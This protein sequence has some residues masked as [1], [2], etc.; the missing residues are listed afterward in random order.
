MSLRA[1][2]DLFSYG[3][4]S[5]DHHRETCSRML[6]IQIDAD[7]CS[8]TK[9][10]LNGHLHPPQVATFLNEDRLAEIKR[11]IWVSFIIQPNA[12]GFSLHLVG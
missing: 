8:I 7:R 6:L 9:L 12:K 1:T 11:D 3:G 10:A 5:H 4:Y 2:L